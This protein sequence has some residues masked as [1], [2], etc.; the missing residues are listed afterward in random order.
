MCRVSGTIGSVG[1]LDRS[2]FDH[3]GRFTREEDPVVVRHFRILR[4]YSS[5]HG[6]APTGTVLLNRYG[7]RREVNTSDT[8]ISNQRLGYYRQTKSSSGHDS[9]T[10]RRS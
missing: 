4:W 7:Q 6:S 9:E 3:V 10:I 2:E 5:T 8:S 1:W